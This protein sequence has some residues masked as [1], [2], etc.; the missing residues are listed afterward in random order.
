MANSYC[1]F[2]RFDVGSTRIYTDVN[3]VFYF[4]TKDL[5]A[6]TQTNPNLNGY[7]ILMVMQA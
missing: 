2:R 5:S 4:C 7:R 3:N 1:A 6:P